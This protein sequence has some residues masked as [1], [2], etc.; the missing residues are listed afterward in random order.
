MWMWQQI[1]RGE[2]F[3]AVHA[4]LYRTPEALPCICY[5]HPRKNVST[6]NQPLA[7][8]SGKGKINIPAK[9]RSSKP[10]IVSRTEH[11][12]MLR[13]ILWCW[14]WLPRSLH[15]TAED[16]SRTSPTLRANIQVPEPL[17]ISSL[18]PCSHMLPDDYTEADLWSLES[19]SLAQ[20]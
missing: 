20:L 2:P 7:K 9:T 5:L 15:F 17:F 19:G 4:S 6:T 16:I 10:L 13:R 18:Q 12:K 1:L 8:W 11:A 3:H 14:S